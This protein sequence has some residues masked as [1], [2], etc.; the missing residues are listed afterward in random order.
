[1]ANPPL[2]AKNPSDQP[3]TVPIDTSHSLKPTSALSITHTKHHTI[4]VQDLTSSLDTFFS[5][6]SGLS[7]ESATHLLST[8]PAPPTLYTLKRE[9]LLGT[10][11]TVKDRE[12]KELAE[13]KNPILSLHAAKI[14]IKFLGE[15]GEKTVV[16]NPISHERVSEVRAVSTTVRSGISLKCFNPLHLLLLSCD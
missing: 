2:A 10:H 7:L 14:A 1:M 9:N 5:Q 4:I 6:S 13:W 16:V 11:L 12:G 15:E 8:T 3:E